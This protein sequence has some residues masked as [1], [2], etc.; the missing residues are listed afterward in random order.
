MTKITPRHR[1]VIVL[2]C[3][4][5]MTNTQAA[6]ALDISRFTVRCH[7]SDILK[8]YG[9][10]SMRGVCYQHGRDARD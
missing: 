9:V 7:I 1:E 8:R 4:Q 3:E 10:R 5:G 6:A 2:F